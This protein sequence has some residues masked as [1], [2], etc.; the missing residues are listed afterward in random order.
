VRPLVPAPTMTSP[1][2]TTTSTTPVFSWTEMAGAFQY[3]L[4]VANVTTL[5]LALR[6]QDITDTSYAPSSPLAAGAYRAWVRVIT[7]YGTSLWSP[8]YDFTI[9]PPAAPTLTSPTGSTVN[10]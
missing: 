5:K 6:N 1:A 3:D 7:P 2:A 4:W 10:V 8:D 9:I